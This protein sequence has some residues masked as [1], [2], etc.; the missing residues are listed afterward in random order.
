MDCPISGIEPVWI[1]YLEDLCTRSVRPP[2]RQ[3]Y[4]VADLC[5]ID[6]LEDVATREAVFDL[7]LMNPH[8][9][10]SRMKTQLRRVQGLSDSSTV[11][12]LWVHS[13]HTGDWMIMPGSFG[14]RALVERRLSPRKIWRLNADD[15]NKNYAR[16]LQGVPAIFETAFP[17][18]GELGVA[19][20]AD[21]SAHRIVD[22]LQDLAESTHAIS[23]EKVRDA[24]SLA[25]QLYK[26][27]QHICS[28]APTD[29]STVKDRSMPMLKGRHLLLSVDLSD[30]NTIIYVADDP[31]REL[32]IP[33][34]ESQ[35]RIPL[36]SRTRFRSLVEA[37]RRILGD[38]RVII[39]SEASI[40]T[41]FERDRD[42]PVAHLLNYL[43]ESLNDS[44]LVLQ[45][46]LLIKF[47]D[48][49][50]QR[51]SEELDEAGDETV[52]GGDEQFRRCWAQLSSTVLV[53]GTFPANSTAAAFYDRQKNELQVNFSLSPEEILKESS[54][55]ITNRRH[56]WIAYANARSRGSDAARAFVAEQSLGEQ[57]IEDVEDAIGH[58]DRRF[59]RGLQACF[60]AAWIKQHGVDRVRFLEEWDREAK[61]LA[62]ISQWMACDDLIHKLHQ[63]RTAHMNEIEG[64]VALLAVIGIEPVEWQDARQLLGLPRHSFEASRNRYAEFCAKI[65]LGLRSLSTHSPSVS[66]KTARSFI[67][68]IQN[69][70]TPRVVEERAPEDSFILQKAVQQVH[71]LLMTFSETDREEMALLGARIDTLKTNLSTGIEAIQIEGAAQRE[72]DLYKNWPDSSREEQAK[73]EVEG[74]LRIAVE[75]AP[76]LGENVNGDEIRSGTRLHDLAHGW[77]ANKFAALAVLRDALS[78][79]APKTVAALTSERAFH[80]SRRPSEVRRAFIALS[81]EAPPTPP[82]PAPQ[83]HNFFGHQLTNDEL[84]TDLV[85]GSEGAVG[86]AIGAQADRNVDF[87]H[88]TRSR[89][90]AF[91]PSRKP[92]PPG[93]G[94]GGGGAG[95]GFVSSSIDRDLSGLLGEAY[96]FELFRKNLPEFDDTCWM[97]RNRTKYGFSGE[98][99]DNLGYD[100]RYRD[101]L[102]RLAGVAGRV[103]L[104]ECKATTGDGSQAF[105]MS[106]NEWEIATECHHRPDGRI[107]I[108]AR[109]VHASDKTALG[110]LIHDPFGLYRAKIIQ[111][112]ERD[113]WIYANP[114]RLE[115]P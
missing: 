51:E 73:E 63:I 68:E 25:H 115:E 48:E 32:H 105:P 64:S 15:R 55:V 86:S 30:P 78:A 81:S 20:L 47:G 65:A 114:V 5:W 88:F 58:G 8:I 66:L 36:S 80:G 79:R 77:W 12:T 31:E 84:G 16:L 106:A 11:S 112:T 18:L 83:R 3:A 67:K 98:G 4:D 111:K 108:V 69:L 62:S 93:G 39:A 27:L 103:C 76:T 102:G 109:V 100:F 10:E 56:L 71:D 94:G 95:G 89:E 96:L 46:A 24:R 50:E 19:A 60:F 41:G 59:L 14:G 91:I 6:G 70:P 43:E 35:F 49:R 110:D 97:S 7:I 53:R 26:R 9:Y 21:A 22:A 101:T 28:Q 82:P 45:L 61:S 90:P 72:E 40:L 107:Y 23:T 34:W 57:E 17:L 113:L 85:R 104:I 74:I 2:Y 33:D 52:D 38:N 37:L 87:S 42:E 29:L 99:N 44:D 13:L 54:R 1:S 92:P 75:L